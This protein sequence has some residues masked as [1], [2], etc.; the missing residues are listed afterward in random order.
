VALFIDDRQGQGRSPARRRI[1]MLGWILL[2]AAVFSTLAF[3]LVPAPYV[4][5]QPGP[6]FNTLGTVANGSKARRPTR[7]PGR[8]T[9]SR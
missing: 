6:V 8:S 2:G 9:C 1:T 7:P 3:T 4:I 5:E